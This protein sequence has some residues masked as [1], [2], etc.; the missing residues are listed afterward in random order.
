ML[1]TTDLKMGL[2]CF[3]TCSGS[4]STLSVVELERIYGPWE[5][6]FIRVYCWWLVLEDG[7]QWSVEDRVLDCSLVYIFADG[8]VCVCRDDSVG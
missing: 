7:V 1:D 4:C 8:L 6:F 3:E 2:V 5:T